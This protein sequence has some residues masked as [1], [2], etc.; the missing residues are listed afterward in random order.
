MILSY[1]V[2][3]SCPPEHSIVVAMTLHLSKASIWTLLPLPRKASSARLSATS[4]DL[5]KVA[6]LVELLSHALQAATHPVRPSDL[7]CARRNLCQN[8]F[9]HNTGHTRWNDSW[10]HWIYFTCP[11]EKEPIED[12][13]RPWLAESYDYDIKSGPIRLLLPI[14]LGGSSSR[15]PVGSRAELWAL[16][17][18]NGKTS[19]LP[20]KAY[21]AV[22]CSPFNVKMAASIISWAEAMLAAVA[23]WFCHD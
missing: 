6:C 12:V 15:L 10:I 8:Y 7:P 5:A 16:T 17:K 21:C 14:E 20:R 3:L 19:F 2:I 11:E 23:S 18:F 1:S 4:S 9:S 22:L 13:W